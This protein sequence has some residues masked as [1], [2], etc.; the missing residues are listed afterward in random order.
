MQ[1]TGHYSRCMSRQYSQIENVHQNLRTIRRMRTTSSPLE[2]VRR[3][4]IPVVC[5]DISAFG[6]TRAIHEKQI[7]Q[8]ELHRIR[9]HLDNPIYRIV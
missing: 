5:T 1:H 8:S 6:S 4:N 9:L 2:D 7:C 3:S